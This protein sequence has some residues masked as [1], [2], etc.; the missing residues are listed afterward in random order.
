MTEQSESSLPTNKHTF[1]EQR[2]STPD[3][4][5][6]LLLQRQ[7]LDGRASFVSYAEAQ[8]ALSFER[9]QS[10]FFKLLNG[11]WKFSY[12]PSPA[13][14]PAGFYEDD[15]NVTSWDNLPVPSN[16]QMYGYGHPH[17]TNVNY[18]FPVEPPYVPTENPTGCY[19]RTFFVP[20]TWKDRSI[21]LR[22]EGVDSAF[23]V[24]VNGS[25]VGY[26]Q[27]SRL[28][29][30]FDV[31][32][33]LRSGKNTVSV[34]VYQW[35]DGS[36]IE[37]QDQW[38]L[39]GI[40]RDVYLLARPKL[41]VADL[42]V[43]TNF[44]ADT[45]HARLSVRA[46]FTAIGIEAEQRGKVALTLLDA[47]DQPVPLSVSE[48]IFTVTPDSP[49]TFL[50]LQSPIAAPRL[51]SAEDPYLYRL[52]VTLYDADGKVLEVIPQRIGFRSVVLRDGVFLVNGVALKLKGV[53]RHDAHPD[54]GRAVPYEAMV[55]D[56]LLMKQHNI[57]TV[58]TSHYPNDSRFL[59]LC[60]EYGLYVIDETDLECHGFGT[61]TEE[62]DLSTLPD[63]ER[64]EM[65]AK[66]EE[67]S[68]RWTSD[69]P[70]WEAAYVDRAARM[71]E[72]DKNHASIIMWSLGNESFFGHNHEAMAAWIR[73][74]DSTRL[75][76]YEGDRKAQVA[77][78]FSTMYTSVEELIKLGERT[79][80]D[81]PHILCEYAHA[82]GNGPGGL[83]EYWDAIYA[84]RRLQGG[85]V[86]E[87]CDHGIRQHTVD[88]KEYFAYGGD[89]GDEPHDGNFVID[90][91]VFADRAPSPG[92]IEYKKVIEPV[93][94]EMVDA[95]SGS[96]RIHNRYDFISLNH[97]N[98]AWS[99]LRDGV[100]IQQGSLPLPEITAHSSAIVQVPF[101]LPTNHPECDYW[102][103]LDFALAFATPWAKQGHEIANTQ[104]CLAEAGSVEV[105]DVQALPALYSQ[106]DATT[107]TITSPDMEV[108]FDTVYGV[109]TSWVY[110]GRQLLE[111]GPRLSFW[112]A[113]TDNDRGFTNVAGKW[114]SFG[115]HQ[116]RPRVQRVHW[117]AID[118]DKAVKVE[119]EVRIAPPIKSWG[120]T[121]VYEYTIYGSGEI[122]LSVRGLPGEGG[123]KT[124]PRI[125]LELKLPQ[126]HTTASWYG[127]GPGESYVDTKQAN[128]VGRYTKSVD[129]LFTSY[130]FPQE[131][132]NRSEVRWVSVM[133]GRGTG[134]LAVGKSELNFSLHRYTTAQLEEARH[135]YELTDAGYLTWHLDYRQRGIGSA[136][137]GPDVAPQYEL[138]NE[139][140]QFILCLRPFST[141]LATPSTLSKQVPWPQAK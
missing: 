3:W 91:L 42:F 85:C 21:A 7:R 45:R 95:S 119:V 76:H 129:E 138:R 28:P 64:A 39:S 90:G 74:H 104:F 94:V 120:I 108:R 96:V 121:C 100:I 71:V 4:E 92:L 38:W 66:H 49:N 127:R 30:E 140:F 65:W 110:E 9:E 80:L 106:A 35:S 50:E 139:P 99:L 23:H 63:A 86:W 10:P 84:H 59:D 78:V 33:Y 116:L 46:S 52:L 56:I 103:N 31:T 48:G 112:R 132:G 102:L 75:I 136:S 113:T 61:T 130:T 62:F 43:Q 118:G 93:K 22:F 53:N 11:D 20:D 6:H 40:F 24:W 18:P 97:L 55:Q 1:D 13:E 123:P 34:R 101:T 115:L 58:R 68:A 82:M 141:D 87:W 25:E 109:L 89:F 12:W 36:Y 117:E 60:D 98:C 79:D 111:E 73:A 19:R 122:V 69:N 14:A 70:E 27:G 133:D 72:R 54:F 15:Y 107:L 57:N 131:N 124:L 37:D 134:L 8:S 51:W 16:W 47:Q 126:T 114:K 44:D 32:S 128:R 88:G 41:N 67:A 105:V 17:Y 135:T 81:K 5:T 83:T 137:C 29:S 26:S 2:P 77:D 125:G